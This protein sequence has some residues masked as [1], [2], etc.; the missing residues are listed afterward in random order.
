MNFGTLEVIGE[1]GQ[2]YICKCTRC[3]KTDKY[4]KYALR[5]G[6]IKNCRQCKLFKGIE[7]GT[8]NKKGLTVKGYA[9]G[10]D[11]KLKVLVTC[12]K[13]SNDFYITKEQFKSDIDC[14]MCKKQ[15]LGTAK[16][17]IIDTMKKSNNNI[18]NKIEKQVNEV[19][20]K[21]DKERI[22]ELEDS[23]NKKGLLNKDYT[24]QVI[25]GMQIVEQSLHNGSYM[26]KCRCSH[27]N[28]VKI[29]RLAVVLDGNIQCD[30]CKD[31]PY[32]FE[33]PKCSQKLSR[34]TQYIGGVIKENNVFKITRAK[35]FSGDNI[36]CPTCGNTINLVEEAHKSDLIDTQ[37]IL[38]ATMDTNKYGEYE[39]INQALGL[40]ISSKVAYIGRDG[41]QRKN[42]LC[43]K[44][45]KTLCL[46]EKQIK[47]YNH[48]LC[49]SNN[50][51]AVQLMKKVEPK[52]KKSDDDYFYY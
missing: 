47:D 21:D 52:K 26:C 28:E 43:L 2:D 33:C 38:L 16:K 17:S 20:K 39:K 8:T 46:S 45:R 13:C 37:R 35:L 15:K 9:N 40:A 48:E 51:K 44:H 24:G 12:S 10:N 4:N 34:Q 11:N 3:G 31:S 19:K 36:Q 50:I 32:R 23:Y 42:C 41:L 30:N 29:E 7:V 1:D 18:N 25:N 22:K 6:S 14:L 27:C 5:S 49:S